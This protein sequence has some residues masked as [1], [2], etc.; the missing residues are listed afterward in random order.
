[1]IYTPTLYR[2][3]C[4]RS[5]KKGRCESTRYSQDL[6]TI[7]KITRDDRDAW[8]RDNGVVLSEGDV[9]RYI[10]PLNQNKDEEGYH[11]GNEEYD[12]EQNSDKK[13]EKIYESFSYADKSRIHYTYIVA[14]SFVDIDGI[15][16]SSM[17]NPNDNKFISEV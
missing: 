6:Y 14:D 12:D 17:I 16:R 13:V 9:K 11:S 10:N 15:D 7:L 8:L 5:N 2:V 4:Q 3:Y 1:M